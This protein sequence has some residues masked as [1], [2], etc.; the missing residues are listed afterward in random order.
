MALIFPE[1][2]SIKKFH[3]YANLLLITLEL[4]YT[5][6]DLFLPLNSKCH[7][8]T[9]S[10][11]PTPSH[12][13]GRVFQSPPLGLTSSGLHPALSRV[14]G[15]LV[16]VLP[17]PRMP[18]ALGT[19]RPPA[20]LMLL[21]NR[22]LLSTRRLVMLLS[23]RRPAASGALPR[24]AGLA[25][26]GLYFWSSLLSVSLLRAWNHHNTLEISDKIGAPNSIRLT[27]CYAIVKA[28]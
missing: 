24:P 6:E 11:I 28:T 20:G 13:E 26:L 10:S 19:S 23:T 17:S 5:E 16:R 15:I 8:C 1:Q 3:S 27:T 2:K 18:T 22:R 21:S 7:K 14:F 9:R 12:S 4:D 25:R